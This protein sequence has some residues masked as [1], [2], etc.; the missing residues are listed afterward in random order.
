MAE[1]EKQFVFGR[2]HPHFHPSPRKFGQDRLRPQEA[3]VIHHD[4]KPRFRVE[5]EIAGDAMDRRRASGHDGKIVGV[6]KSGDD[7][8]GPAKEPPFLEPREV[9][10]ETFLQ[11][12]L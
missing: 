1:K 5:E 6:C 12:P 3:G 8:I 9:R 7:P 10:E 4:R 2:N 11:T